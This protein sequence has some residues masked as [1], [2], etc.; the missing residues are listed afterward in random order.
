[1]NINKL[2]DDL[3]EVE[4]FLTDEE[5]NEVFRIIN[6]TP[7]EAWFDEEM[8]E[9]HNVS[10][11]WFGKNLYFNEP[12]IFDTV[13]DKLRDLFESYS[14]YPDKMHL[15]RYKKGDFIKHHADQWIPDLPYY[16]GYGFC[17]YFNNDYAGGELDY[18]DIDIRVKPKANSLYIHGGHIVHGS[19]PVLDD[20]IRYF[21]T[22]FIHGT[23]EKPTRLRKDLFK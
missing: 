22:V 16:I 9:K 1:M 5:L 17:L 10:D 8:R 11:F 7:E 6:N 12:T 19:L 3:Y 13:N 4:N 18:P 2:Y 21:S 20:K 15:Q 14:F 23:E